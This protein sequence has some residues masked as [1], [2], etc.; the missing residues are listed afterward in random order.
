MIQI[1]PHRIL[2]IG[3]MM[4][5]R[6]EFGKASRVSPE[7]PVLVFLKKKDN[8]VLGGAGNVVANLRGARQEVSVCC[9]TGNDEDGNLL[10]KSLKEI[11]VSTDL[12]LR[13][14]DRCTT[15]KTRIVGQN[16][17]QLLRID[18]ETTTWISDE[19][20]KVLLDMIKKQ[21]DTFDAI[22]ISDYCKGLMSEAFTVQVINLANSRGIPAYVDVKDTNVAKYRD[23][24]LLKP[25]RLELKNLTGMP[26][27]TGEE[28][29]KAAVHLK[30]LTNCQHILVT[31]AADGMLLVEEE[32]G[33]TMIPARKKEVFDVSGAGDTSIAYLVA[34]MCSGN[35]LEDSVYVANI[36]SG[37]KVTKMGTSPVFLHEVLAEMTEKQGGS[38]TNQKIL[39]REDLGLLQFARKN[40]KLIFTNGCFDIM[41]IGHTRYLR[42]AAALGDILVVGLN[43]DASVKR[44]KGEER[45]INSQD[46]RAEMLAALEFIDYIVIFEDDTPESLIKEVKPDILV[47]GG[48]WKPDQIVGADF[49]TEHGGQALIIPFV[50]G[51]STTNIIKAIRGNV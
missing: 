17:M 39:G 27:D 20:A 10:E 32:E 42:E 48:D 15:S 3:D 12:I 13:R 35:T 9:I 33:C 19:D 11:G 6:Y 25:N 18:K 7:A 50:E 8:Y 46:D 24:F 40:K 2:V 1:Q 22:L 21:I 51:K 47:K 34:S 38:R 28:L 5:D 31:L 29:E 36:A 26:V 37:I 49:V 44:L 4:I 45:P 16:N 41:H 30:N 43:S 14:A 23:A